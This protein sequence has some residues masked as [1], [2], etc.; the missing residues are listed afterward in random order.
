MHVGNAT[1][2][3]LHEGH[4][5]E[6]GIGMVAGVETD[7]E[8]LVVD[9]VQQAL[10]LGFEIHEAGGVGVDAHRQAVFLAADPGAFRD[11]VTKGLPFGLVH[12]F[13]LAG[14]AGGG[15]PARRDRIDQHD[16]PR[17]MR[18]ERAGGAVGGV[19]HVVP[20]GRVVIGAEHHAADQLQPVFGQR[21]A[22]DCRVFRHI[23]HRP[24]LDPRVAGLG[25]LPQHLAPRR[26]ARVAGEF[27]APGAG[28]IANSDCHVI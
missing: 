25:V 12:L 23:A 19:E 26:V 6:T 7:L 1:D 18:L 16:M 22:E 15:G 28:R 21:L 13:G 5:I 3:F 14:A 9:L 10:Q 2:V 8:D 17:A 20:G 27:D 4:R 11:P 24:Q